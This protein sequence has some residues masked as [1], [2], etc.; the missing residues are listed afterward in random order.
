MALY[1]LQLLVPEDAVEPVGDALEA[2]EA[3]SVGVDDADAQTPAE[4]A[5]FG[6]PGMPPP[7]EGWQRSRMTAL[8][9]DEASAREAAD[10]LAAQDFFAGC[11]VQGIGPVETRRCTDATL[12][13]AATLVRFRRH[14]QT[15][16]GASAETAVGA[17]EDVVSKM[18]RHDI[19]VEVIGLNAASATLVDRHAPL[20]REPAL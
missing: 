3:L 19:A 20:L 12:G 10:L 5:L 7:R 6:E 4:Q 8:F 14:G 17:L 15:Y 2:L 18:R 9:A 1:E 13:F 16:V 11:S